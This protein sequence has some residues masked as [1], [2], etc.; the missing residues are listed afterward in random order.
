MTTDQAVWSIGRSLVMKPGVQVTGNDDEAGEAERG[1]DGWS[2]RSA[3]RL[4]VTE[5]EMCA[6][7][8]RR[9][10]PRL[11]RAQGAPEPRRM[12]AGAGRAA[13]VGTIA[14]EWCPRRPEAPRGPCV[15]PGPCRVDVTRM[16]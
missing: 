16:D 11:A 10:G 2:G 8:G 13:Y 4:D 6:R 12:R 1:A 9:A 3:R 14:P 15:S 5:P 7:T